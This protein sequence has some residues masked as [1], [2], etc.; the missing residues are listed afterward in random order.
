MSKN[1]GRAQGSNRGY[2]LELFAAEA[3]EMPEDLAVML[4]DVAG[5]EWDARSAAMHL[6]RMGMMQ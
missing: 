3:V 4:E 2:D 1:Q 5:N 6:A